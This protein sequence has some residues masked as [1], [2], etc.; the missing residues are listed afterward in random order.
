[1]SIPTVAEEYAKLMEHIRKAQECSAMIAHLLN[2]TSGSGKVLA[3]GW[4]H[5]E[6]NFKKIGFVVTKLAQGRLN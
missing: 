5:V 6:D 3:R 2:D 4:L 1:M